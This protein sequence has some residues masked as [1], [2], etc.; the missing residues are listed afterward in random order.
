[1]WRCVRSAGKQTGHSAIRDNRDPKLSAAQ[2]AKFG[3]EF[4]GQTPLPTEELTVAELLHQ[5]GYATAAI[6]KWGLGQ[7]G[8]TGDPLE[9]GF[10][11]F[12]GYNCQRHAHN[13]YPKYL[14]RNHTKEILPGNEGQATGET[15]SQDRFIAEA[16]QFLRDHKSQPW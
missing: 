14:W 2:M 1:R 6:G 9:Q 3:L 7:F 10:D 12:Y 16:K 4:S 15:H 13:H 8:T 5:R 11:F